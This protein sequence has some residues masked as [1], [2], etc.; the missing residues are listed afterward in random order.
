M[1]KFI[2]APGENGLFKQSFLQ[3]LVSIH[4]PAGPFGILHIYD[5]NVDNSLST[6]PG[7]IQTS[8]PIITLAGIKVNNP[9][10]NSINILPAVDK[11]MSAIWESATVEDFFDPMFFL[12]A[13]ST[14]AT[15]LFLG[16]YVGFSIPQFG[17]SGALNF[18]ITVQDNDVR[19]YVLAV[20]KSFKSIT[21]STPDS[22]FSGYTVV[23]KSGSFDIEA[24]V[25]PLS[26]PPPEAVNY[27]IF[28]FEGTLGAANTTKASV[29]LK[30]LKSSIILP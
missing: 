15:A 18:T 5:Q 25:G 29:D 7:D 19:S 2:A 24:G 14:Y 27:A 26:T 6:N 17:S 13:N 3:Q 8:F 20:Y 30:T 12:N 22:S 9:I 4:F 23:T 16:R 11:P 1:T 28:P 10:M 21:L